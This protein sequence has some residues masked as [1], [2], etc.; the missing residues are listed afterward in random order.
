MKRFASILSIV[1]FSS[2]ASINSVSLTTIP[3]QRT[4]PVKAEVS[5]FII[6]GLNFNNDF[7]DEVGKKLKAECRDGVISGILTKDEV[8]SYVFAHTRH[9]VATGYCNQVSERHA[10]NEVV[11]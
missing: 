11:Q 7:V 4:K 10:S 5:K 2:C 9:I 3:V 1:I 6:L 8:I